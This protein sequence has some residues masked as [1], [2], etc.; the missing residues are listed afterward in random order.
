MLNVNLMS[1]WFQ[2]SLIWDFLKIVLRIVE[3]LVD[4]LNKGKT[5]VVIIKL[6]G[7]SLL[8]WLKLELL[9]TL[10]YSSSTPYPKIV[11]RIVEFLVDN[12][13]KGKTTVVI[14]KLLG[15]SLLIW[16]KLE[17]LS[18]L[19][20]SSSTPYPR[21]IKKLTWMGTYNSWRQTNQGRVLIKFR[22]LFLFLI[23][24]RTNETKLWCL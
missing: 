14:I 16:L 1:K 2:T 17:L 19:T 6:L 8:I 3:F 13:N 24:S 23:T 7:L 22:T 15:L 12:L 21:R 18:T 10:T 11:L 5:T 4:N 20:Y 9:S